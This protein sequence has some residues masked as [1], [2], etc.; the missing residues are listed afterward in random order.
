MESHAKM[1]KKIVMISDGRMEINV[2]IALD[3]RRGWDGID[4]P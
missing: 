3:E 1:K 4:N 2:K